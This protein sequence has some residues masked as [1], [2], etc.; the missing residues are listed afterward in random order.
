ML[1]DVVP[2][3]YLGV[4][5]PRDEVRTAVPL[6]GLLFLTASRPG[7]HSSQRNPPLLAGLQT[8]GTTSWSIPPL[9]HARVTTIRAGSM[10]V[11]GV[12]EI[13]S[14][15]NFVNYPQA[16]WCRVVTGEL[17]RTRGAAPGQ[18]SDDFSEDEELSF[19]H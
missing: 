7:W 17:Q 15:R 10:I 2:L 19:A 8:P 18:P 4:K 9:D 14:G 12:E 1:V 13:G 3:R 6:R 5:R 16:W 11:V